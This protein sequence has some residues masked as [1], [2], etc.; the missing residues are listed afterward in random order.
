MKR[1]IFFLLLVSMVLAGC[2][3]D[4]R[5]IVK[6]GYEL[7][8]GNISVKHDN[9]LFNVSGDFN[10]EKPVV[11]ANI[12][13]KSWE[14]LKF[15]FLTTYSRIDTD[16]QLDPDQVTETP[17]SDIDYD[18]RFDSVVNVVEFEIPIL[19]SKIIR[20]IG[21]GDIGVTFR[22]GISSYDLTLKATNTFSYT[23]PDSTTI[24][25]SDTEVYIDHFGEL[26]PYCSMVVGTSPTSGWSITAEVIGCSD[27]GKSEIPV[28]DYEVTFSDWYKMSLIANL[29]F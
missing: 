23:Y 27:L 13:L 15:R 14:F 5:F 12:P 28:E 2:S 21:I 26:I 11:S 8:R 29:R 7:E 18:F 9:G 19:N 10:L 20:T 16:L 24:T 4:A 25:V 22:F 3:D 6:G 17:F 1:F